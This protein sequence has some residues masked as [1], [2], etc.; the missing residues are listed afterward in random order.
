LS[1]DDAATAR[2]GGAA[3]AAAA[4]A[5]MGVGASSFGAASRY[6]VQPV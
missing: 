3:A 4:A 5:A 1:E 6:W 2:E